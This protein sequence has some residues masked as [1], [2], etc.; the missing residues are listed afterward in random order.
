M[1]TPETL[2]NTTSAAVKQRLVGV[3]AT[4][5]IAL[6]GMMAVH[7]LW[8]SDAE[9]HVT[10]TYD[11]A[12]GR[13]A[14]TFAVLA[15]VG[16]AFMTGRRKVVGPDRKGVAVSLATR[17][18][19]IGLIGLALGY[20]D[21]DVMSV[22]LVYYAVLFVL[23]I[24]LT[25]LPS[26]ALAVT[27]T[28]IALGMPVASHLLRPGLPESSG[29][30]PSFDYLLSH[31]VDLLTELT[32]TG[33]YP[34]LPWMAYICAGL[35]VGRLRLSS[36]RVALK[37]LV[38]GAAAA[39]AAAAGSWWALRSLGGRD[40]LYAT[41]GEAGITADEVTEMLIWGTGGTTPTTTW[42]WLATDAPHTTTPLDLL[43]TT[44][45]AVAL[46][47]ALLLLAA[48]G[49]R[50]SPALVTGLQTL[51]AAG[52]MTLTLYSAHIV[53]MNSPLDVFDATTGYLV[54]VLAALLF[55][56]V[57]HRKVGRGPLETVVT[58]AA[59][60]ARRAVMPREHSQP[61]EQP[62]PRKRRER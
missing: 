13:S 61:R 19:L 42:W 10:W 23:A 26:W 28:A 12:A 6:L 58:E 8:S 45:V 15:G 29:V 60:G 48:F 49:A 43:H 40:Q 20:A 57:W 27:G 39:A 1:A 50:H 32:L 37:L 11:L 31:P 17:A 53:F 30:N 62:E 4:R 36:P 33:V 16:I 35:L 24:P 5:G 21:S 7:A 38:F 52:G 2:P 22:I 14:A 44:G 56:H 54:Q 47:G 9:G 3:D 18:A 41:A 55:A 59:Q 34:A 25:F 51:G 46:L